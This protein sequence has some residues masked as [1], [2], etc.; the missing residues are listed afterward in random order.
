MCENRK[1]AHPQPFEVDNVFLEEA[2]SIIY[3]G[4]PHGILLFCRV[5]GF[6][7]L[8]PISLP[9]L[10]FRFLLQDLEYPWGE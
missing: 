2:F 6:L 1:L 7:A 4:N 5:L 8:A 3:D 9:F 10:F